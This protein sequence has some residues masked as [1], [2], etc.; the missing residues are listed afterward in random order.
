MQRE[1]QSSSEHCLVESR[2]E[3]LHEQSLSDSA[4]FTL[5]EALVSV[6]L[7]A[8][9]LIASTQLLF[10]MKQSSDRMSM[11]AE[12]RHTAQRAMEFISYHVRTA[13]DLNRRGNN[14]SALMTW[15]EIGA[16]PTTATSTQTSWN[17][18]TNAN[19]ADIGTDILTVA[20]PSSGITLPNVSWPGFQHGAN[21]RWEFDLG[22]PDG[23]LNVDLF[24]ELTNYN[25]A[26][27]M[28]APLMVEGANGDFG[29]YQ[30]TNYLENQNRT[31]SCPATPGTPGEMHVVANPGNSNMLNPPGGH[32]NLSNQI[33]NGVQYPVIRL[34]VSYLTFRVRNGWLEQKQGMFDPATDN[35]GTSFTRL[36]PQIED[37]QIAW[38]FNDGTLWN[39][40][41]QQLPTAT[42]PNSVPAQGTGNPYDVIN[43][44]GLR[45]SVTSQST[46]EV[47]WEN[48]ARFFRPASEDRPAATTNDRF[49][50]HRATDLAMVRNRALQR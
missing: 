26:T 30:I 20:I 24:K 40:T 25:S 29:F 9:V 8:I 34:G 7:T 41:S 16:D 33:V 27:G 39:T 46:N 37:M 47:F 49:Y 23:S 1:F 21:A 28:S 5:V 50:H 14:P 43:V 22:C 36:L 15:Y 44:V 48:G 19:L 13:A 18:V 4:G 42:Y 45:V 11:K 38:L 6:A 10:S 12:A 32:P 35:P 17:N 2:N 3:G 31:Q